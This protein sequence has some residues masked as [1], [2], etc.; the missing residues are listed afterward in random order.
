VDLQPDSLDARIAALERAVAALDLRVAAV[1]RGSTE[2]K[3]AP[4]DAPAAVGSLLPA[5]SLDIVATAGLVGRTFLL[6]AGAYLLRAVTEAGALDRP[7]GAVVAFAYAGAWTLV[8]YRIAPHHA[9]SATFFGACTV[10]IGFPLLWEVT[11]RFHLLTPAAGAAALTVTT[12]LVLATAWRR[13]LHAL[14]W[15]ATISAC[16]LASLLLVVTGGAIPFATFLIVLGVA[17]LWLGYDREWTLL[18]WFAAFFADLAVLGLVVRALASPPRDAPSQVM[19]VQLLL[20]AGYLGSIVVRTIVRGRA[21]LPFEA[22]QTAAMLLA[23]LAGALLIARQTGAGG[24]TLGAAL[25]L[26]AASCYA[27][28]FIDA[29]QAKGGNGYFYTAL[30]LVFALTGAGLVFDGSALAIAWLT[31]AVAAAWAAQRYGRG[32]LAAH[33]LVYVGAATAASGLLALAFI[34][35]FGSGEPGTSIGITH[36]AV[37]VSIPVCSVLLVPLTTGPAKPLHALRL[38]FAVLALVAVAGIS[39]VIGRRVLGAMAD[40]AADVATV[41]TVRTGVIAA[42]AVAVAWL[43][44]RVVTREFGMLLYPVLAWGAIKLLFEDVR[45]SPPSLLFVAFALYGGA[46]ILG[47]RI[48]R[49]TRPM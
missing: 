29:R 7:T 44:R 25:L 3:I 24:L 17:T 30:A 19:A 37:L 43:G 47:P 4:P 49:P 16:V 28:T 46:L 33:S 42:A 22:A 10:L 5:P 13:N 8:A 35:L 31:A 20:L 14:A 2:A 40:T 39:V 48:A 21:V 18:R 23:G 1:E 27:V 32:V 15:L 12:A 36:W 11:A 45:T 26:F 9:L 34:G 41:A 6:F 38:V